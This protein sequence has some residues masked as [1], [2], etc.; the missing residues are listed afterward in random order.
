MSLLSEKSVTVGEYGTLVAN[1]YQLNSHSVVLDG[2]V[3]RTMKGVCSPRGQGTFLVTDEATGAPLNI[4]NLL[5]IHM[6]VTTSPALETDN[7]TNTE[8]DVV[9]MDP[10]QVEANTNDGQ[11]NWYSILC[12]GSLYDN[13][14][15][16]GFYDETS[17]SYIT[18]NY[19]QP[20]I[21]VYVSNGNVTA[22]TMHF[23]FQ[24][25]TPSL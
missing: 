5:V 22:G 11:T 13:D 17:Y 4:L 19:Y 8:I 1:N 24:L 9:S 25:A 7:P 16:G 20:I 3:Y 18:G 21:G 10:S 6:F 2:V 12:G 14:V 23:T 15:N